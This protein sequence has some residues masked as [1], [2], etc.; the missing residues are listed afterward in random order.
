MQ[1]LTGSSCL[2]SIHSTTIQN[3]D[4][5]EHRESWAL[6]EIINIAA[7]L[8]AC[9]EYLVAWQYT[10]LMIMWTLQ[11]SPS[12]LSPPHL[13]CPKQQQL[14]TALRMCLKERPGAFNGLS[15]LTLLQTST[16]VLVLPPLLKNTAS[17]K[18]WEQHDFL[19][20]LAHPSDT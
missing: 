19:P 2:R 17:K 1:S 4:G 7:P 3:Y 20:G 18:P 16:S 6:P 14:A 9:G 12:C 11:L 8:W 10:L 5:A 13:G 15:Q